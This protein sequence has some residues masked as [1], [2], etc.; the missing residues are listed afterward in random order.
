MISVLHD[1]APTDPLP[2]VLVELAESVTQE[3]RLWSSERRD[4]RAELE[5]HF[6][7]GLDDLA[8]QGVSRE[9]GIKLLL[10]QF[11][12]ARLTARLIRRAKKRG[13]PMLYKIA[14]V[15]S[16]C[17]LV[18]AGSAV[19]L[20]AWVSSGTPTP[21]V[22]YI[23]MINEEVVTTPPQDRAWT[24]LEPIILEFTPPPP[25][26]QEMPDPGDAS[27]DA[28]LVWVETNRKLIPGLHAA[29]QRPHYG[30]VYGN[31]LAKP[32][33]RALREHRG[34]PNP[35]QAED[36]PLFPPTIGVILP[37]LREMRMIARFAV[38]DARDRA[39]R[40]D[41]VLAWSSLDMAYR[42]GM[43][44]FDG[45]TLIEQLVGA[46][47]VALINDETRTF[48]QEHDLPPALIARIKNSAPMTADLGS[49]RIHI[50]GERLMFQDVMQYIFTD[51]GTGN[52]RLI[53]EQ[54]AK[55][56]PALDGDTQ[57]DADGLVDDIK[58]MTAAAQHADR[59]DTLARYDEV[60][61]TM[62]AKRNLPLFDPERMDADAVFERMISHN[63]PRYAVINT[64]MP[65]MQYADE[66][67]RRARMDLEAT[68][69]A[70]ALAI[71]HAEL[72]RY[73]GTLR[74]LVPAYLDDVVEDV[75]SGKPLVYVLNGGQALLYS[76]GR[77]LEDDGGSTAEI[78][79]NGRSTPAD[80]VY[81]GSGD[82]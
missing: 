81:F 68:R 1:S 45:Q 56:A 78:E 82:Q 76:V 18:G 41:L 71:A 43:H 66:G 42:L 19:G 62:E 30:F 38:L 21:T 33:L 80:F 7:E 77:N 79:I 26:V 52:G 24:A 23:A 44:L 36:D 28:V 20:A 37:H 50:A 15:S 39:A 65:S 25:E 13:R 2:R 16:M 34:E 3:T 51:D 75:Y 31:D 61:T 69:T 49:V 60:W 6:R 47:I 32:F 5:S 14:V 72:E 8:E 40:G 29:A 11:G 4:V 46:A 48:V 55:I 70:V 10:E 63:G 57:T 22:D 54:F 27:W 73:P 35:P 64:V 53:P 74:D 59:V 12:D 67:M 17:L 9:D 58:F